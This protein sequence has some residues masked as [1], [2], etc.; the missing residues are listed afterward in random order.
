MG[1]KDGPH[2]PIHH[3]LK[4]RKLIPL[5]NKNVWFLRGTRTVTTQEFRCVNFAKI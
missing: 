2:I 5:K 3:G 4:G 1:Q